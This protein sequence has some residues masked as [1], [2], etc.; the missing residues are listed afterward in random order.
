LFG[1]F[2]YN[3][4]GMSYRF[5]LFFI[6]VCVS[7]VMH[8]QTAGLDNY[9]IIWNGQSENSGES[10]PVGGGDIG[11]NVW[12]ENGDILFYVSRSGAFDE[13]NMF[14]KLGR[15]RIKLS[16]NAFDEGT[17]F[18][19]ELKLKEGN[20]QI[21]GI[22]NK[23]KVTAN[24][25]VD[26]FHPVVNV[27]INSNEPI[28]VE[29]FYENWRMAD[30]GIIDSSETNAFR[31]YSGAP[32]TPVIRKDYVSFDD[33][34]V[35]FY[36]KNQG[37]TAFDMT[38]HYEGLD[39]IKSNLWDPLYGMIYGG[40]MRGKDM[41]SDG[42]SYGRYADTKYSAWKL[43]S[44][45]PTRKQNIQICINIA[46][47]TNYHDWYSGLK[48][49]VA[50][51]TKV[52][53]KSL[54]R[55]QEWWKSYWER[56]YIFINPDNA[57][58]KSPEWQVGRNYQLFRYQLGC[59]AYGSFPTKFNGGLFTF[60]PSYVS[61]NMKYT[62]DYR[63]WG[64]GIAT[65]QNQRLVYWPM[66]K[67]GDFDMMYAE[68]NF[69]LKALNN[70]ELRTQ[71]YWGH[72]GASFTEQM[73]NFGLPVLFEYGWNRPTGYDKGEQFNAWVDYY[74]DTS[75]E[76]CLMI[77][78]LQ[79]F[80]NQDIQKYMPLI[81]SCL[82]FFDEHYQYLS[83]IRGSKLLDEDGHLVLYPS[84]A[85]ETYKMANNPVTT[86]SALK[87]VLSRMLELPDQY[88]SAVK[89]EK[90][91]GML[92]RIPPISFR[93]I[94]GHK[95]ISPAK[96]W[97]RINNVEKPQLYPVFPYGIYGINK[98]DLN[99]AINTWKYDPDVQRFRDYISWNQDA[100]FC[101]RLGL[102]D[103][104]AAITIQKLQDS[105][106]RF[107]TFWGPGHDWVP[108][109]NWGGSGMIGLQEMLMQTDDK[110]IYLLPAWPKEWDVK[111][112]LHAPYNTIV[113]GEVKDGKV[114]ILNVLPES[115]FKDVIIWS[116]Y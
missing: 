78:D 45:S 116:H 61:E 87:T 12:V 101:A 110:K 80:T 115:R 99:I 68:F 9:N 108:D 46:Q 5:S 76:F 103:E 111:F 97:E 19:Q 96:T 84:T 20:I 13:N 6:L 41:K 1:V 31:A 4:I 64:G 56:S 2:Q 10:M 55:T 22:K 71:F 7:E 34:S 114:K 23:H 51:N 11:C 73:E 37:K 30:R 95:M 91:S 107:P 58:L 52:Q 33:N 63:S 42:I 82:V 14:P 105:P 16:P 15:V 79:R 24:I 25:W 70:A 66:L 57:D 27:N 112:K 38:V 75:L 72:K 104:A 50:E 86:I 106:R 62:P 43:K 83:L 39:S 29:A 18:K 92:N 60:D 44:I 81:E 74:Y 67:S 40:I 35:L 3:F 65:A 47:P 100:I 32:E 90:W 113:E 88:V 98:P 85:C 109:H 54:V 8:G 36:H 69:Y 59:N 28:T 21:T 93:E 77:L 89:R 17:S 48:E 102:T 26:V 94:D 53:K 49:I